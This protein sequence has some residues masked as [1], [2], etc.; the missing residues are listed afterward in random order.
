[1]AASWFGCRRHDVSVMVNDSLTVTRPT[2]S[3]DGAMAPA[4]SSR[5]VQPG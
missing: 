1:M 4:A 5:N 3:G 2:H